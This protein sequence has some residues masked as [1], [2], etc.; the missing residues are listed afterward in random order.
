L[1]S[2]DSATPAPRFV[3]I[4]LRYHREETLDAALNTAVMDAL[5]AA[6]ARARSE[7]EVLRAVR[8][9]KAKSRV[10]PML[11]E[12]LR[13]VAR[14]PGYTEAEITERGGFVSARFPAPP[15]QAPT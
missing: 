7:R 2:T 1:A 15:A 11:K 13:R 12:A 8:E 4:G 6:V 9:M 3:L 10:I 14:E 5:E